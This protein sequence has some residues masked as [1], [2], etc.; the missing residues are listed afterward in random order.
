MLAHRSCTVGPFISKK[1]GYVISAS[2]QEKEEKRTRKSGAMDE[3][4]N[5]CRRPC[6][7]LPERQ[8]QRSVLEAVPADAGWRGQ[9][10]SGS[11]SWQVSTLTRGGSKTGEPVPLS[12][13]RRMRMVSSERVCYRQCAIVAEKWKQSQGSEIQSWLLRYTLSSKATPGISYTVRCMQLTEGIQARQP[14]RSK[15]QYTAVPTPLRTSA[16]DTHRP[17]CRAAA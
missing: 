13:P 8:G 4:M 2:S 15:P 9:P 1:K 16:Q 12:Q 6:P 17:L 10:L 7:C 14:G 3:G 5:I 11:V